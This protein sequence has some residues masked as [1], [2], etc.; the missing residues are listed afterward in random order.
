MLA[1]IVTVFGEEKGKDESRLRIMALGNRPAFQIFPLNPPRQVP[2]LLWTVPPNPVSV[3]NSKGGF[4][5]IGLRL[6]K[7][8]KQIVVP[9]GI[10]EIPIF[11]GAKG[12][13]EAW[14]IVKL[15]ETGN[16]LAV[17]VKKNAD[18]GKVKTIVLKDDEK[19]F[20]E[21]AVRFCNLSKKEIAFKI[22]DQKAFPLKPGKQI[23]KNGDISDSDFLIGAKNQDGA[24]KKIVLSQPPELK[25]GER[26]AVFIYDDEKDK[27][28]FSCGF[29]MRVDSV[30]EGD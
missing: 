7:A 3:K 22:G 27:R 2:L 19:S 17:L 12:D 21:G 18:W 26:L 25:E 11:E 15:P 20:P 14:A 8:T 4:D 28:R 9:G 30:P 6:K 29:F 13:G 24:W 16:Y 1:T 23:L 5:E 10:A